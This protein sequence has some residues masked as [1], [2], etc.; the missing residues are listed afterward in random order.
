MSDPDGTSG[1]AARWLQSG[2]LDVE[3]YGALRGLGFEDAAAAAED[4][5]AHGMP[6]RLSPHPFLDFISLP[7]DVRR[8]WRDSKVA[9]VLAHL[10][11][12]DGRLR[13]AGPLAEPVDPVSARAEML[14][15]AQSLGCAVAGEVGPGPAPADWRDAGL[16]AL[17]PDVTSIVLVATE[18]RRT[19]RT[20]QKLLE[21]S[22]DLEVEVVVVD[23]GSAPH[24]ALGLLA[25]L[26]GQ[27]QVELMRLPGAAP[28]AA[29]N[30]GI[31]RATGS[32]VVVLDPQVVVRRGWLP[33]VLEALDDPD[34]AGVQ[35]V[36]LRADDTIDSAGLVVTAAG[37]GL[38]PLLAGHP[39]ED[40]RRLEGQRLTALSG[41]A[42]VLRTEDVVALEGLRP[43]ATW[44]ESALDLCARLL[45]RRPA[46]FRVAA[47]SLV[48]LA[49]RA[50]APQPGSPSQHP[51]LTPD[52]GLYERIGFLTE[53]RAPVAGGGAAPALVVTGR[54]RESADQL[55]WSLKLPSSPGPSGDRWGDTHFADALASA[56]GDLGQDVVTR[57]RGAHEAGPTHLDDVAMAVRGL[58][59][60]PPTPGQVNVLW[61]I[62]HPDDV[63]DR[64]LDGYDL[65]CAASVSWS[66]E[67]AAR[68]GREVVPLLQ[69]TEFQPPRSAPTSSRRR[70][71]V[72][73]VGSANAGRE[74][75][76]V[77][78]AVEAGVELA[79][80]GPGWEDLPEGLWRGAYVDNARLPELYHQHG[81]VL[82][83]HWPDMAR[84]GFIANR[85]FDAVASGARVICD[86]VVGV[87]DVFDRRDVVVAST[88]DEILAAVAELSR[89][90]E[91]GGPRPGLSFHDRAQTLLD[92][93]ARS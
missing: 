55:R 36:V 9:P 70:P 50:D 29:A 58:Y 66:A 23:C 88:Q 10:T 69:A 76:L 59:P 90:P 56:L 40:A 2:L 65:V 75:P 60:I 57:R 33:A 48:T 73:F 84:A 49:G 81:I 16:K 5:I 45:E 82:A 22:G 47:T 37:R 64:E 87:H 12:E 74:R 32:V 85:V 71:S 24:A 8:A 31:A 41:E 18:A 34:V 39:K 78:K 89:S 51:L 43:R 79:V 15:L 3:F 28:A 21:R 6:Q 92:L 80:Y 38:T 7:S 67:L 11:G 77:W 35:P 26:H 42:M 72:V 17:R 68:T 54:R 13:P 25:S 27:P 19:L 20:V 14:A 4:F 86:E 91:A 30:L 1:R 61:V 44:A 53:A 52:P 83:D 62:S 93:V 63:D 46:G